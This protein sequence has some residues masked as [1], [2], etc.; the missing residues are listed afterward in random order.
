LVTRYN[1]VPLVNINA[2]VDKQLSYPPWLVEL[3]MNNISVQ[4]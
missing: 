2:L 4:H 1:K 3:T